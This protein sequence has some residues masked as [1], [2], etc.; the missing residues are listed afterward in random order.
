MKRNKMQIAAF[1]PTDID[2][3]IIFCLREKKNKE[4]ENEKKMR[5][6]KKC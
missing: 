5:G 3:N 1:I 6:Q 2:L 4:K